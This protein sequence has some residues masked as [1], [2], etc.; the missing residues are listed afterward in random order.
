MMPFGD[1]LGY[2]MFTIAVWTLGEMLAL[3]L[4]NAIVADR[5]GPGNRGRY[6]GVYTMTFSI[7]FVFAPAIGTYVYARI[8]PNILWYGIGVLGLLLWAWALALIRAF[9]REDGSTPEA[10]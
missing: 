9:R 10:S 2:V 6:M 1:S 8:G 4:I 7:A 3:P 5:A